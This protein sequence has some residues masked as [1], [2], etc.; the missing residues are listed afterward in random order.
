MIRAV[1]LNLLSYIDRHICP[2]V[3]LERILREGMEKASDD[4]MVA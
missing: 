4:V 2:R 1:P 3:T